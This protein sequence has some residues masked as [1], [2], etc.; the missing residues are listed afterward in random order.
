[1]G[2]GGME[3][4]I[5][6]FLAR[7]ETYG[8]PG[9]E[10]IECIETH[11]SRIYL[12]GPL[13]YKLKK[14]VDFGFLDFTTLEKRRVAAENEVALNRRTAPEIYLGT[15][16]VR[17]TGTGLR[18]GGEEGEVVDWLVEMCRF[19]A[20]GLFARLADEGKLSRAL[21]E[22]LAADVARFHARAEVKHDRGGAALFARIVAGNDDN[23]KGS[24]GA[25]FEAEKVRRLRVECDRLIARHGALL[26][27]RRDMGFVR[28]CH[29]DL[30][31]GNVTL[32]GEKPVI[33]DCIEFSDDIAS[34][35]I[36]YDLGFLLMDLAFR[37]TSETRL[38]GFANRALNIYLDH[39]S[40]AEI[41]ATME[42]LALLP[43]FIATRAA[44]RAKVTAVVADTEEKRDRSRAYL[45]FALAALAPAAPRLVAVG[46]LSG[47]GKST[48]ATSLAPLL[49]GPIGAV[50]LRTD[51]LRKRLFGVGP[52]ERLPE[53]AYAPEV[54][55]TVYDRMLTLARAAL[56]A[57]LPVVA[58]AVFARE[59]ER[60]DVAKL[61]AEAG[62]PFAG[63]WLEAPADV[64]EARV[65]ARTAGARDPSDA[66]VAV[67]RQQLGYDLGRMDWMRVDASG[68]PAESLAHAR[69][70]LNNS[71]S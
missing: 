60:R 59:G 3:A 61:A 13:A 38:E 42:G 54:G 27:R 51:I 14:R 18:L 26:D 34:I 11:A 20:E 2:S 55:A 23:L 68:A 10:R 65:A 30:H 22:T 71:A 6:A 36:L 9:D 16:P 31:L 43:L 69:D 56:G 70:R 53:A 8:L 5:A 32:I 25:V 40:E 24:I 63:L 28:Q 50:H 39:V 45:D 49:G 21:I 62:V 19:P 67:L 33:F 52:L 7:P 48:L 15:V 29:G 41:G 46:G 58:D 12:A 4:E 47:T 57:G 66:D 35:D 17:Q 1:M 44:V 64:L 37:A